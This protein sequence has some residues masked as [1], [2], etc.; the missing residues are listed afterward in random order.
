[1]MV[2]LEGGALLRSAILGRVPAR[3]YVALPKPGIEIVTN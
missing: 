2:T 3:R 1:M